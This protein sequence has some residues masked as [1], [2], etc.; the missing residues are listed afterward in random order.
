MTT[1]VIIFGVLFAIYLTM[2]DIASSE[3]GKRYGRRNGLLCW[4]LAVAAPIVAALVVDLKFAV[5][6]MLVSTVLS[7]IAY[8]IRMRNLNKQSLDY[9]E[10]CSDY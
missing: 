1:T 7:F 8:R 5:L 4:V 3:V 9:E 2:A 10:P 6:G